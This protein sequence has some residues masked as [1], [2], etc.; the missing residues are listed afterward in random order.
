MKS[1]AVSLAAGS[2]VAAA[3]FSSRLGVANPLLVITFGASGWAW[4]RGQVVPRPLVGPLSAPMLVFV[5]AS[6]ASAL[7]SW[8]PVVSV[9]QLPR[10]VVFLLVP[11][12][13]SLLTPLWWSRL[14][15]GL[16]AATLVLSLWGL[17]Q[18]LHGYNSLEQRIRG[19]LSHYMTYA[20]WLLLAVSVLLAV[21]LLARWPARWVLLVPAALAVVALGLSYTRSAWVGLGVA[22]L[23]LA[24]CYHRRL[25]VAY[26]LLALVILLLA[27]QAVR[28]RVVSIVDLRQPANFDRLCMVYSGWQMVRDHALTGVGLDMVA[29]AYPLYRRDDAPRYRVPHLHN[30]LLQI[31]AERGLVAAGAYLWF[32]GGFLV[33]SWR[34]LPQLAVASRPYVAAA[35][36][37]VAASSAAGLFEYNFWDAE[38]QYLTLV[39]MGGACGLMEARA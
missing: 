15:W 31:A 17:W 19:P 2:L 8:D 34:A 20:G 7:F 9:Q 18:Y 3:V 26:P 4:A 22:V 36:T 28:Q 5:A 23:V 1:R 10:L 35:L 24:A 33:L 11:L 14:V 25:L 27:P 39:L 29:T 13:A 30:N 32:V 37:A 21:A 16:A 6:L 38:L 12:S